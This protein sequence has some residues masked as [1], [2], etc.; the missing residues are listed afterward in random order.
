MPSRNWR[1]YGLGV[2]FGIVTGGG[3]NDGKSVADT[4]GEAVGACV[5]DDGGLY[6]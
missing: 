5:G 4:V 3:V 6:S 1:D 2:D